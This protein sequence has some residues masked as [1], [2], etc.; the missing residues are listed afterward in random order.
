MTLGTHSSGQV[1][2]CFHPCMGTKTQRTQTM[3]CRA[4]LETSH[5]STESTDIQELPKNTLLHKF[6]LTGTG[7]RNTADREE[8]I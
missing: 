5:M 1:F 6:Y 4:S 2:E 7:G 3:A 8:L